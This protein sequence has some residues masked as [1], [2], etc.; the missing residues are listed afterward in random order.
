M[1]KEIWLKYSC[2]SLKFSADYI[3]DI[4]HTGSIAGDTEKKGEPAVTDL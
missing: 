1:N 2:E 3:V 4:D